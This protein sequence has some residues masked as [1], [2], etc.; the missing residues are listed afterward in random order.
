MTNFDPLHAQREIVAGAVDLH[1][2]VQ[3][4]ARE[5][6]RK[7]VEA[8]AASN[9][10]LKLERFAADVLE[11]ER[12]KLNALMEEQERRLAGAPSA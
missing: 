5:A 4:Q 6:Q 2:V 10:M 1:R 11:R 12:Q 8:E 3:T 7:F 9:A